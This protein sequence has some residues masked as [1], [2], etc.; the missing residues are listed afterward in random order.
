M[1]SKYRYFVWNG[2]DVPEILY[3]FNTKTQFHAIY[4]N[5]KND[6]WTEHRNFFDFVNDPNFREISEEEAALLL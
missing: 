6:S 2:I 3:R 1:K 4:L 5:C